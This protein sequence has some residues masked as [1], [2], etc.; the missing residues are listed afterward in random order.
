M[1]FRGG[2]M[3][4]A[5]NVSTESLLPMAIFLDT[6]VLD[7][8]PENLQSGSLQSLLSEAKSLELSVYVSDIVA[9]EWVQH[10]LE[11]AVKSVV[12]SA[13]CMKQLNQ[14]SKEWVEMAF[15][16]G[17]V[18]RE[19]V[20][21]EAKKRLES[22]GLVA[23]QPPQVTIAELSNAAACKLP[24]FG[25]ANKGFKDELIVLTMLDLIARYNY[26]AAMLVSNDKGFLHGRITERFAC[27]CVKFL[28]VSSL[29]EASKELQKALSL[30]VRRFHEEREKRVRELAEQDWQTIAGTAV[31]QVQTEGVRW[32]PFP[33]TD[34]LPFMSRVRR[35]LEVIPSKISSLDVGPTDEDT[36]WAN[37]TLHVLCELR[38]D[39]E[40]YG[41]GSLFG[42]KIY[43]DGER[44]SQASMKPSRS[45]AVIE[46]TIWLEAKAKQEGDT[47]TEFS[48][49]DV[50][51]K[52]ERT[53]GR[54]LAAD[55]RAQDEEA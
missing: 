23:L 16:S 4:M 25:E 17:E 54:L 9:R 30:D 6:N 47:W 15:P 46:R 36:G 10:R 5:N 50:S 3:R 28:C 38:V 32:H 18:L 43:M 27:Y 49:L 52:E 42:H 37:V 41:M 53:L 48:L 2:M 7:S 31:E 35:I 34:E 12:T 11:K 21:T 13:K 26:K 22:S 14:Y 1:R 33:A 8:L 29:E 55:E 20:E 45:E 19:T 51:E 44:R 40:Q 39:I 24:P